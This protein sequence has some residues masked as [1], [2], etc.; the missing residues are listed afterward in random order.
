MAEVSI[1]GADAVAKYLD[2]VQKE[3]QRMIGRALKKCGQLAVREAKANAPKSPTKTQYSATLKRKRRTARKSFTPGGLEKSI[4]YEVQGDKCSVFVGSNSFAGKYAKRIHDDRYKS[5]WDRGPGS[6]A[7][8]QQA[9]EKFI[10]R[11]ITDNQ[12]KFLSI[13]E[14][15]I[16]KAIK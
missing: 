9:R 15:E 12:D 3:A 16:G 10:E 7:K 2:A 5:W 11:A 14:S 4:E 1:H 6:I 13:I 8:G